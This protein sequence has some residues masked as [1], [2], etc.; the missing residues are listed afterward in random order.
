MNR[1]DFLNFSV[2]S[3]VV[4]AIPSDSLP[5]GKEVPASPEPKKPDSVVLKFGDLALLSST[6]HSL[7]VTTNRYQCPI[8]KT[9]KLGRLTRVTVC[10]LIGPKVAWEKILTA[11]GDVT[12][13]QS[14]PDLVIEINGY[15]V[16]TFS[17]VVLTDCGRSYWTQDM[18]VIESLGILA[19]WNE[20]RDALVKYYEDQQRQVQANTPQEEFADFEERA[21]AYWDFDTT[22]E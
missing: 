12:K 9:W 2:G 4:A 7:E 20:Q 3:L 18:V 1:R 17:S 22:D 5:V 14:N 13:A 11:Y 10:G 8:T 21:E 15:K 6:E 19:V 16:G